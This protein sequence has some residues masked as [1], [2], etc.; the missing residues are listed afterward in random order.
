[1]EETMTQEKLQ[2]KI[3]AMLTRFHECKQNLS[4]EEKKQFPQ[5]WHTLEQLVEVLTKCNDCSM[6]TFEDLSL[7]IKYNTFLEE[8]RRAIKAKKK[9][10]S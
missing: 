1:M 7:I 2:N 4:E 6:F 10:S 5:V 8:S 3:D 9:P